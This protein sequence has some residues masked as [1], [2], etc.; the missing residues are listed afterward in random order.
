MLSPSYF[1]IQLVGEE[2]T[3]LLARIMDELELDYEEYNTQKA[4]RLVSFI[5]LIKNFIET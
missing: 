2:T 3:T 1:I 5:Q 4:Y